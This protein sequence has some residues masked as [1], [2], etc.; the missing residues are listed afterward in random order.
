MVNM[1][2]LQK[3][4]FVECFHFLGNYF[5]PSSSVL[6]LLPV[7]VREVTAIGSEISFHEIKCKGREISRQ[8]GNQEGT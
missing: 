8:I 5:Y 1:V 3:E 6:S 4:A 2:T 7:I